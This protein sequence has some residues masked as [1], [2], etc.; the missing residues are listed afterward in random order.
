MLNSLFT[1]PKTD[2]LNSKNLAGT[3]ATIVLHFFELEGIKILDITDIG[4]WDY[5]LTCSYQNKVVTV[6]KT[7]NTSAQQLI[8]QVKRKVKTK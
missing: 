6:S 7:G 5:N 3:F 1:I 8:N 2:L 4:Q